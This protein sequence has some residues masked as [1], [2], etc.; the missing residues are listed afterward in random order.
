VQH[1]VTLTIINHRQCSREG[2]KYIN[3]VL[4]VRQESRGVRHAADLVKCHKH[5][6]VLE[7]LMRML[8]RNKKV[9][10]TLWTSDEE[11]SLAARILHQFHIKRARLCSTRRSSSHSL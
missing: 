11:N 3:K 1:F 2:Q 6:C 10:H 4:K 9:G 7:Y 5:I 8:P